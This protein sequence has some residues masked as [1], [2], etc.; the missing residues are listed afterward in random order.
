MEVTIEITS[1]CD[2]GCNYCSTNAHEGGEHLPYNDID[3]FLCLHSEKIDRINISG[4]E[5]LS[6]PDFWKILNLCYSYTENV[7]IYTNAIRNIIYNSGVIKNINVDANVC[8]VPG[9]EVFIPSGVRKV[10]LLKLV[11]QGRAK[12][13]PEQDIKVSGNMSGGCDRCEE[14]NHIL[15]QADGQVVKAPC[16]KLY[17]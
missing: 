4:G 15:L 14:C 12:D 8:I 13:I 9:T 10:H 11:R 3:E 7:W 1:W 16:Q 6:H 5:P 17:D 2:K